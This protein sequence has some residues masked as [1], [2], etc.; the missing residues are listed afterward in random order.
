LARRDWARVHTAIG[1]HDPQL[2]AFLLQQCLEKYLK[3][4]L[5]ARGWKLQRT[6]ELDTLLDVACRFE[7]ELEAFQ[8]LCERVSGYYILDRYP[9]VQEVEL[10]SGLLDRD[11]TDAAELITRLHPGEP[12]ERKDLARDEMDRQDLE[13]ARAALSEPGENIPIEAVKKDLGLS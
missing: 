8:E 5:L 10:E 1:G 6:H 3:A 12:S 9:M 7:P 4:F 13:H 2:A 11:L